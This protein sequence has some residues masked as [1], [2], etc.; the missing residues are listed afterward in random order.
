MT[1]QAILLEV[2]KLAP[3]EIALLDECIHAVMAAFAAG[4][5]EEQA[6]TAA[7]AVIDTAVDALENASRG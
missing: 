3:A 4:Q 6:F 5:T 7:R 1:W 2:L